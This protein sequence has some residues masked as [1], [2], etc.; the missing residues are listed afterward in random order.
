[1]RPAARVDA[2]VSSVL[3]IWNG[4]DWPLDGAL[5]RRQSA[6]IFQLEHFEAGDGH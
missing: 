4:F 2:R 6:A 3:V 5:H 1:M